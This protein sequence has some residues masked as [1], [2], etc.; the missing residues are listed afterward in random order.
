M[1]N[2]L[3]V[4]LSLIMLVGAS[5][6]AY[7][8]DEMTE[9]AEPRVSTYYETYDEYVSRCGTFDGLD[10][11]EM[12]TKMIDTTSEAIEA[13]EI[14]TT[15]SVT[16]GHSFSVSLTTALKNLV[17]SSIDASYVKSAEY[18]EGQ[19]I[20]FKINKGQIGAVVY[21][22]RMYHS[23]GVI[24]KWRQIDGAS[25]TLISTTSV[26]LDAPVVKNKRSIGTLSFMKKTELQAEGLI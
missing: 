25:P 21:T 4:I 23:E 22:P 19:E 26:E 8:I 18:Q 16:I 9:K 2:K 5:V 10:F 17:F 24:K 7:A 3:C 15:E 6:P 14:K 11:R 12:V 1:K 13:G 20:G